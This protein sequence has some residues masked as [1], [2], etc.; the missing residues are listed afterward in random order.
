MLKLKNTKG[1]V[2]NLVTGKHF[3]K[4]DPGAFQEKI[5]GLY[6]SRIKK[7]KNQLPNVLAESLSSEKK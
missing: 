3:S 6:E 5:V 1:K 7:I 2:M 4:S